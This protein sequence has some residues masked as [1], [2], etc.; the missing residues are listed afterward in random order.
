[1][2]TLPTLITRY[3]TLYLH[4]VLSSKILDLAHVFVCITGKQH[5]TATNSAKVKKSTIFLMY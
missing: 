4:E 1:M 3:G 2:R 5:T